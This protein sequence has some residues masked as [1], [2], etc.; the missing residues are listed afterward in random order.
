MPYLALVYE[1]NIHLLTKSAIFGMPLFLF[2]YPNQREHNL[3][4]FKRTA[5]FFG[6][7]ASH[8]FIP[9]SSP[10]M[11]KVLISM[12]EEFLERIDE[13]AEEEQRTR[14][15]LIRQALRE[16][17]RRRKRNDSTT[18]ARSAELIESLLF[19]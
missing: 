15:E 17:I 2:R 13:I 11:A 19:E 3:Q 9:W 4:L 18:A 14:S 7:D 6:R 12:R 16:Y 1:D 10:R 8:P 5:C